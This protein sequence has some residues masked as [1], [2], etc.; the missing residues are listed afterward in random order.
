MKFRFVILSIF[1]C[2]PCSVSALE[3]DTHG[4][5]TLKSYEKS[6]L[7]DDVLLTSLGIKRT[8]NPF[9]KEY[10]D[11]NENSVLKGLVGNKP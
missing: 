1:F 3:I 6:V 11:I 9:G 5:I 2:I 8:V 10:Y 7:T 4:L